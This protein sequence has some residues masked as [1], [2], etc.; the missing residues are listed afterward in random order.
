MTVI[1]FSLASG[2][3]TG[4][5]TRKNT[6]QVNTIQFEASVQDG[7]LQI[8]V[9]KAPDVQAKRIRVRAGQAHTVLTPGVTVKDGS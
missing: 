9:P 1:L 3:A 5:A 7:V 8:L 2:R 4:P 6:A